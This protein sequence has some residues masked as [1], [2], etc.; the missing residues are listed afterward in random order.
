MNGGV[1]ADIGMIED[2]RFL[3]LVGKVVVY[4]GTE[5]HVGPVVVDPMGGNLQADGQRYEC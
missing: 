3:L 4:A 2:Q 5:Q 1:N